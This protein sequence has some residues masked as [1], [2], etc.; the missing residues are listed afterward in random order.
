MA[1]TYQIVKP[2]SEL[3][4]LENVMVGAFLRR[5]RTAEVRDHAE[6]VLKTVGL[7]ELRHV[8]DT[9]DIK[10]GDLLVSS[11]LGQRFPAG[12]PVAVVKEVVRDSGQPFAIVRAEPTAALSRSRYLL[13]VFSDQRSPEQRATDS[14]EAQEAADRE[15]AARAEAAAPTPAAPPAPAAPAATG[16]NHNG[17]N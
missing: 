4:V 11:G 1:R 10:E 6:E 2:F 3:T 13:L 14:A 5:S 12:Y 9:A 15:A 16:E 8:A 7:I 17:R